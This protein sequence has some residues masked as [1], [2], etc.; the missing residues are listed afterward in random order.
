VRLL[1]DEMWPASLAEQLGRRGHEVEAV[2]ARADLRHA[3]DLTLFEAA[4][5]ERLAV[6][7]ENASDFV[8]LANASLRE[9][10]EFYGLVLTT[11]AGFPRGRDSTL[12]AVAKALEA[13]LREHAGGD[14]LNRVVSL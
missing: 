6:F 9:G 12:G 1:I 2:I 3:S 13:L 8:P 14:L 5:V 11:N 10:S 7:T 4:Q